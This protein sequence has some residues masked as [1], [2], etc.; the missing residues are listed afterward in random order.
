MTDRLAYGYH[1]SGFAYHRLEDALA[2]I[3]ECGYVGVALTLDTHHLPPSRCGPAEWR[4][5]AERLRALGLRSVVETGG[6]YTLD[7]RRK[8]HPTLVSREGASRR[9]TFIRQAIEAAGCL[10]AE[11]VSFWSG[12][13]EP[14]QDEGA[15]WD[16]LAEAT[17]RLLAA[18]TERGVTLALEPEPGM[19]LDS[20]A[21]YGRLRREVGEGLRLTL[22]LGH[23]QCLEAVSVA[24]C[25]RVWGAALASVH[26]EDI[27]GRRHEH[28]PLGEGDLDLGGALE[29]LREVRYR[30]LVNVELGRHSHAAPEL[31]RRSLAVLREREGRAASRPASG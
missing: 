8:H 6:R 2:L 12:A 1:T 5:V 7:P 27:R 30:G 18:A 17:C 14:G 10:G 29:A 21:G 22:D 16:R 3:A 24:E 19:L 31:A 13:L 15:A 23:C 25:V 26:V 4:P 20:L 9:E 11:A 28:L